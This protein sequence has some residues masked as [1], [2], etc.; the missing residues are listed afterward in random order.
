MYYTLKCQS[1]TKVQRKCLE[2]NIMKKDSNSQRKRWSTQLKPSTQQKCHPSNHKKHWSRNNNNAPYLSSISNPSPRE[3]TMV[4]LQLINSA[5]W[6]L[7]CA[8]KYFTSHGLVLNW[9]EVM[10]LVPSGQMY[11]KKTDFSVPETSFNLIL[12]L[13]WLDFTLQMHHCMEL[14]TIYHMMQKKINM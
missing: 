7:C 9:D 6:L 14:W 4:N 8:L 1:N 5:I 13:L 2:W 3:D 12:D 11:S 10:H